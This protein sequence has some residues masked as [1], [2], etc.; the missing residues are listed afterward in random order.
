MGETLTSEKVVSSCDLGEKT[1][2]RFRVSG[3]AKG[4]LSGTFA[5]S[6]EAES[7]SSKSKT[8]YAFWERFEINSDFPEVY[9]SIKSNESWTGTC[10]RRGYSDLS[11]VGFRYQVEPPQEWRGTRQRPSARS[12]LAGRS[13]R[14]PIF[15]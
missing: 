1:K 15:N 10:R 14:R 6:G 7:K 8:Y 4:P 13:S 3:V 12:L 11:V 5:A 2:I 9:G